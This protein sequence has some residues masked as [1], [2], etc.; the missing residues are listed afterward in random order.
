MRE[1]VGAR[2]DFERVARVLGAVQNKRLLCE[3][4]TRV[5]DT[6]CWKFNAKCFATKKRLFGRKCTKV[7]TSIGNMVTAEYTEKNFY[8]IPNQYTLWQLK[9]N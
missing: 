9:N 7:T 5:E 8:F 6:R 3:H 2:E 1:A 4:T